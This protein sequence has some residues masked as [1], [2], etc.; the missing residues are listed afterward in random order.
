MAG[1]AMLEAVSKV[2]C[3]CTNMAWK[4]LD[5]AY[6]IGACDNIFNHKFS[7]GMFCVGGMQ[8]DEGQNGFIALTFHPEWDA[9][10]YFGA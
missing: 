7:F 2:G 10:Y 9:I 5:T 8:I 3:F 1:C 6:V 4:A